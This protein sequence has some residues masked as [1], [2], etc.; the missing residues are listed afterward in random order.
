MQV[1]VHTG[2]CLSKGKGITVGARESIITFYLDTKVG[3]AIPAPL[4]WHPP[5]Q[6]GQTPGAGGVGMAGT[7]LAQGR[8][9]G[10]LGVAS[11]CLRCDLRL[12][13]L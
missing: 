3:L 10:V 5:C 6:L 2:I 12:F 8:V 1:W 4:G 7:A 9:A 11:A 13:H